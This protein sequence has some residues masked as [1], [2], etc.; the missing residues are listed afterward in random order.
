[1]DSLQLD[2]FVTAKGEKVKIKLTYGKVIANSDLHQI[3]HIF[4][5]DTP[6]QS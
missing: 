3:S 4:S 6:I 2:E 1:M 5:T